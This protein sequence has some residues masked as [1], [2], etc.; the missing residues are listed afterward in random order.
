MKPFEKPV[1]FLPNASNYLLLKPVASQAGVEWN[2]EK[3]KQIL[4]ASTELP[5]CEYCKRYNF[6]ARS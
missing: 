5:T 6:E 1:R 4:R 3:N 2:D